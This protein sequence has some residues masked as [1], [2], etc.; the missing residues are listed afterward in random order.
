ME[1]R[2][3]IVDLEGHEI[4]TYDEIR[5]GGKAKYGL[6]RTAFSSYTE[7]PQRFTFLTTGDGDRL[8]LRTAE[9][10]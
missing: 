1:K 5:S 4:A 8:E 3:E 2:M 10:R 7:N 9:A 6:L